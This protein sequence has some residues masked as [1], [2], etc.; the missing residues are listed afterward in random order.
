MDTYIISA[1]VQM[2]IPMVDRC[3]VHLVPPQAGSVGRVHQDSATPVTKIRGRRLT[4]CRS[5]VSPVN[6][7]SDFQFRG[8]TFTKKGG[9]AKNENNC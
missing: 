8:V 7:N 3:T 2:V 5:T 4:G 9:T 6:K 1:T